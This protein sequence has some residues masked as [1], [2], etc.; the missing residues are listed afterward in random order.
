MTMVL[1]RPELRTNGRFHLQP[2]NYFFCQKSSYLK[3]NK[4][5]QK[6]KKF[7][8]IR[9]T[10]SRLISIWEKGT[11]C[12]H[13]FSRSWPQHG[14]QPE[15]NVFLGSKSRFLAQES[16]FCHAT[17]NF[18]QWLVRS[19]LRDGSFSTLGS[20]FRLFLSE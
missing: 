13:N 11:F 2:K 7:K 5:N 20:I 8:K 19:P 9:K 14:V 3:K 16:D 12:F 6:F 17:P 18:L 1:V 15:V 10:N 4:L